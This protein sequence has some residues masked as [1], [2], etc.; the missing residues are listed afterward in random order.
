[1]DASISSERAF[2][3]LVSFLFILVLNK[4]GPVKRITLLFLA[5]I[6]HSHV[7]LGQTVRP[8]AAG[9]LQSLWG[10]NDTWHSFEN[11]SSIFARQ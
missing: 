7:C 6:I 11:I 10:V 8:P 2:G 1:M 5:L 4:G 9:L 3:W